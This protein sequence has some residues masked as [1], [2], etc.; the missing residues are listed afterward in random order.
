MHGDEL[1]DRLAFH[2]ALFQLNAVASLRPDVIELGPTRGSRR[3]EL[4]SCGAPCSD[5]SG[6]SGA[7]STT[8]PDYHG[9]SF[10]DAPARARDRGRDARARPVEL[11]AFCGGGKDSLVALKLLER[12]GLAV[13]DAR[14]RA[15]DLRQR[16]AAARA[17]RSR[18]RATARVRAE[19]QWIL[20]DFLDSPVVALR[21]ELGVRSLLAAE[22]PASVF[23]A[24]P[25]ALARGYRGLVVAHEAQREYRQPRVGR[26]GGQPPVGQGLGGRAP[27]RRVRAARA[28]RRRPLLQRAPADPRRGD[29]RAARARR[30]ARAAHALV[31]RA[32]AVVRRLRE[33]RL[34]LAADG[35]APAARDRRD[36]VRRR[37]RRAPE[38]ERWLRELFGLAEHTPF[39]CVG[40]A[41]EAR[42]ALALL[43]RARSGR[44]SRALAGEIGPLD[45]AGLARPLVELG[46]P[47]TACRP[48]VAARVM[49]QLRR[50]RRVG[51][52]APR[53]RVTPRAYNT[54]ATRIDLRAVSL[55]PGR[56]HAGEPLGVDDAAAGERGVGRRRRARRRR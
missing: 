42:L 21:P 13:R 19:R 20:D 26:R 4:Q 38:N 37:P 39:E 51:A 24:L 2:V 46:R 50:G 55:G 54:I 14:L 17:A 56:E 16:G 41:R 6:R 28:A 23:A 12:A 52:P 1:L 48:N 40:S 36:D 31:Q 43:P 29:L 8:L 49:P 32:Q 44:S 33:V 25:L 30:R 5:A 18:R 47:S 22:T 27:A 35:G 15:L 9:P 10:A 11:L 45:I 34:R 3:A 7:G 53:A